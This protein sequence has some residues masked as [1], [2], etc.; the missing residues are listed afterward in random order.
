MSNLPKQVD[1]HPLS[2]RETLPTMYD[3]PS[4]EI[5][6]SGV[7]DEFHVIQ[8]QLLKETFQPATYQSNEIF[9]GIDI[10]FYF[11]VRHQNWY[12]RPDWFATVGVPKLYDNIDLRNSYVIWQEGVSPIVIMEF[13]SKSTEKEDLGKT[14]QDAKG[15]P[16][17]WQVYEKILRIP[18]YITFDRLTN[19]IQAFRLE[20]G[21]Y[22]NFLPNQ[23][24]RYTIDDLEISLGLWQGIYQDVE[25][26]WLRWFDKS[27]NLIPTP[28]ERETKEKLNA[29]DLVSQERQIA[30]QERQEKEAL[31]KKLEVL[32]AKLKE[33][34]IDPSTL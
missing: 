30:L 27:G 19:K 20:G 6:E 3:L 12:K 9:V 26:P 2:P 28:V 33:M 17:K 7:P 23:D 16:S 34:G 13:L 25:R 29:L 11:D 32:N 1:G 14:E 5:G 22:I 8:P 24:Q 31:A 18:Y 21:I 15:A 10:N 4:E